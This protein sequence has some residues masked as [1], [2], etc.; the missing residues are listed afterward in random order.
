LTL[1]TALQRWPRVLEKMRQHGGPDWA[2]LNSAR[3]A[4]VAKDVVVLEVD[5]ELT[6]NKLSERRRKQLV[7]DALSQVCGR[8]YQVEY[9]VVASTSGGGRDQAPAHDTWA[10][11]PVAQWAVRELGAEVKPIDKRRQA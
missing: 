3:P 7:E 11:D 4:A 10:D 5:R 8:R 1:E 9:R 2:L 6:R